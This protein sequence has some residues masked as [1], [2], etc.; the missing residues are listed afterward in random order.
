MN[1]R[2]HMPLN[3][4]INATYDQRVYESKSNV[5]EYLILHDVSYR[6]AGIVSTTAFHTTAYIYL[7]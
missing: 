7:E 5:L 3:I 1:G 6:I 2:A 4:L